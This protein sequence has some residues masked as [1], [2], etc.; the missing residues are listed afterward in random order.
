[1]KENR[2][3]KQATYVSAYSQLN[4]KSTMNVITNTPIRGEDLIFQSILT[5]ESYR[6]DTSKRMLN[7]N[8]SDL[9]ISIQD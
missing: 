4:N 2:D 9:N 1:M 6:Q 8:P 7:H 3:K 5:N